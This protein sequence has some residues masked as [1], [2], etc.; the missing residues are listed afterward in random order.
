[1]SVVFLANY[2]VTDPEAFAAYT[3][4][5]GP[6]TAASRAT[7]VA[8]GR[9]EALEGSPGERTVIFSFPDRAAFDDWY[10]SDAYQAIKHLRT[11]N[12]DGFALV[13]EGE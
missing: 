6:I 8:V 2:T 5:V 1:M 10:F 4:A 13:I 7:R 3:E 9:S 11:D 12:S